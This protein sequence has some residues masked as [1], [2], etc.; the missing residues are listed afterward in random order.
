MDAR[1]SPTG[2][3]SPNPPSPTVSPEE[4]RPLHVRFWR[5]LE[6]E[7]EATRQQD[8][9]EAVKV[10]PGRRVEDGPSRRY[11]FETDG[12]Q[13]G[14]SEGER[15][16]GRLGEIEV[17]GQVVDQSGGPS[18]SL[19]VDLD[20]GL[21]D[22]TPP[23]RVRPDT[24]WMTAAVKKRIAG[25]I[26]ALQEGRR[27]DPPF[28]FK[29]ALRALG[30]RETHPS[31]AAM[32][33]AARSGS[34]SLNEE[35]EA[36]VR[37]SMRSDV[38]YLWG[39]PG[40]GKSM[41]VSRVAEAHLH[42]GRSV[43]VVAT[44]N[45]A[46]D[47][48]TAR[49]SDRLSR[50]GDLP[51]GT[52]VRPGPGVTDQ[53]SEELRQTV[54]PEK[55]S[56][57]LRDQKR[58]KALELEAR[59]EHERRRAP[60]PVLRLRDAL[61]ELLEEWLPSTVGRALESRCRGLRRQ[62]NEVADQSVPTPQQIRE[63]GQVVATTAH[64]ALLDRGLGR[65]FDTVVID[66]ASMM[67]PP[68]AY[69]MAGR[70]REHVVIAGDFQQLPPVTVGPEDGPAAVLRRDV[71]QY[72]GIP[73]AVDYGDQ[74][75][76]L[77]QLTTQYR[78]RESIC[79]LASELFYDG[80]LRT[81]PAVMQRP[82]PDTALG[83]ESLYVLDTSERS[84]EVSQAANGSRVNPEHVQVDAAI[85]DYLLLGPDGEPDENAGPVAVL[86]PFVGQCRRV[87]AAIRD[88]YP[89][90]LVP[91]S[92]IHGAQGDEHSVVV[93]D[94]VDADGLP[95]SQYLGANRLT[96]PGARLINV[97]VT[98]ATDQLVVVGDFPHLARNGGRVIRRLVRSLSHQA[99]P[100]SVR[101]ILRGAVGIGA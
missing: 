99:T 90:E 78:M 16:V 70:A 67:S 41:T 39:P 86:S 61:A 63:T 83:A 27:P 50:N 79:R 15:V 77:V 17:S 26:Q 81:A 62:R 8:R 9:R 52:L 21:G 10:G 6:A 89:P 51:V 13:T 96:A 33:E 97:A 30:K 29:M 7:V 31:R 64:Q 25:T 42:A 37:R 12:S 54:R 47:V 80:E 20:R 58:R 49:L 92:T 53:L 44:S 14:L 71:F 2:R 72:V 85:L 19:T 59:I 66:E 56:Q 100:V 73:D 3:D 93:L 57:R 24:A 94:L 74:P 45:Q 32:P 40:T 34:P 68:L 98:R 69:L 38:T 65:M 60:S 48:V 35:Q 23:G 88:R 36:A 28:H 22:T 43:L 91:V 76:N 84:P 1:V 11:R 5:A 101:H 87:Q 18:P 46:V 95:I 75:K 55:L 82:N 4:I